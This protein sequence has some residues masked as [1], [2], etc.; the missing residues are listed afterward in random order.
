MGKHFF[1][2]E[3]AMHTHMA[4]K[5]RLEYNELLKPKSTNFAWSPLEYEQMARIEARLLLAS[6]TGSIRYVNKA[7]QAEFK[8]RTVQAIGKQRQKASY[9]ELV[10]DQIRSN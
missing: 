9:K 5:H 4:A 1:V 7:I 2:S 3:A 10:E 8:H 6:T